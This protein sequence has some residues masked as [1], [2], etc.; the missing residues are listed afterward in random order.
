MFFGV[1]YK[2]IAQTLLGTALTA[3]VSFG[4]LYLINQPWL[5]GIALAVGVALF[6]ACSS[7]SPLQTLGFGLALVRR[8]LRQTELRP[9]TFKF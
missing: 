2:K 6:M 9:P 3:L 5:S 8:S 7:L 1:S 4:A